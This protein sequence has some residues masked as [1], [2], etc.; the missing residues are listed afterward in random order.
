MTENAPNNVE[1][2]YAQARKYG[3]DVARLYATEKA[4]R[5]AI[6]LE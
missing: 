1:L 3:E 6:P 2:A 5:T 4:R